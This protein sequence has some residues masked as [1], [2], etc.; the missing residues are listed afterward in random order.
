MNVIPIHARM[1]AP[2]WMHLMLIHVNVLRGSQEHIVRQ[3]SNYIGLY[4][5]HTQ[6]LFA[7]NIL[8]IILSKDCLLRLAVLDTVSVFPFLCD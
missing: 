7:P 1:E 8:W 2:V 4:Y 6:Y 5:Y 3:V